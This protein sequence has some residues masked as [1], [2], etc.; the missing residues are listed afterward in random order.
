MTHAT[1]F[2]DLAAT[3]AGTVPLSRL[4][5]TIEAGKPHRDSKGACPLFSAFTF[6]DNR[7]PRG[8]LRSTDNALHA[9]AVVAEHVAAMVHVLE[10]L[11]T[12]P[13]LMPLWAMQLERA[14]ADFSGAAP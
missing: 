9:C 4:L 2:R 8:S 5:A 3:K 1:V 13:E 12:P 14:W 11:G 7:T 6:G 10:L